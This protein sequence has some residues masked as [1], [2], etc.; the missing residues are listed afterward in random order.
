MKDVESRWI[1]LPED[2]RSAYGP[3]YIEKYQVR[4]LVSTFGFHKMLL[5]K[6]SV[7]WSKSKKQS[8]P[9]YR[10]MWPRGFWFV[11]APD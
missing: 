5:K 1:Q 8:N 3:K 7:P 9:Y 4:A 11:K 2:V 10:P 6:D